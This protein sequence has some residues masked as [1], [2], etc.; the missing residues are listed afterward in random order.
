MDK[1]TAKSFMMNLLNGSALGIVVALVPGAL[2]GELIKA[3]T[4]YCPELSVLTQMIGATNAMVGIAVGVAI[5]YM[6]KFTPIESISVGLAT[7]IAGGAVR[8]VEA[9]IQIKGTGDIF[10]MVF[11]AGIA[12]GLIL[13]LRGKAHGYAILLIPTVSLFVAGTLGRLAFPYFIAFSQ[14]LGSW[15]AHL[16]TLEQTMMAVLIAVAFACL[17]VSPVSSV[18]IATAIHLAGVGS[19]AANLGI[20]AC[21]FSLAVAGRR[22]N[23]LGTCAA[24]FVGSPK[25]SMPNI[26]AK[27]KLLLPICLNA[28]LAGVLASLF[29]IQGTEFSAGFGLSG[30]IGPVNHLKLAGWGAGQLLVSLLV[31]VLVP[32]AGAF[33]ADWLFVGKLKWIAPE[34]YRIEV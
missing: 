7:M 27:P 11:T 23:P 34:D 29:H 13:L 30:L 20:C 33:A 3:L 24:H 28:A 1:L 32:V 22:V 15:I 19:G 6:F 25:L 18:G 9:G 4:P 16:L 12:A 5:G 17:I 14:L 10:T 8:F 2:L 21:A 31:F 26:V